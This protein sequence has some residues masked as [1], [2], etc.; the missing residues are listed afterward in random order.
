MMFIDRGR[1]RASILEASKESEDIMAS[2]LVQKEKADAVRPF[3]EDFFTTDPFRAL[4][5]A[6]SV[7]NSLLDS[8]LRPEGYMIPAMDLYSKDGMYVV[9]V[10]L[11]G[12]E[13]KDVNIDVDGNCLTVSGKYFTH[14]EETEKDKRYHYR[15]LRK[16]SFSRSVTLPENID[17]SKV[18]ATFD[19]GILKIVIPS[20]RPVE[21]KKIAIK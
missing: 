20:Q 2:T 5:S 19:A 3:F 15:E 7:F 11:P 9:E 16:G 6:R 17:S 14:P 12:F 10:A 21:S 13:K 8:T 4:T 18:F 1:A